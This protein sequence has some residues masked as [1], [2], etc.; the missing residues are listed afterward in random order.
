LP[1]DGIVRQGTE[2]QKGVTSWGN[3]SAVPS[4]S[5]RL[6]DQVRL[7]CQR[8]HYSPRTAEA[9]VYWVRNYVLFHRKRH[10][11]E[12]G[13][14]DLEAFLNHLAAE[15][16]VSASTQSQA[17]N[18]LVFLYRNVLEL[19]LGWMNKRERAKRSRPLPVVLTVD[20]VRQVLVHL[21]GTPRL[22]A[23]LIYGTGLRVMEC[24]SLQVQD[25]DFGSGRDGSGRIVVRSG[26]AS[27][28]WVTLLPKN[29]FES[30]RKYLLDCAIHHQNA[31]RRG[32]GSAPLPHA[33]ARKYP[34]AACAW[35]WQYVFP[36]SVEQRDPVTGRLVR[37]HM[38]PETL[39]RA[40]R[41]TVNASRIHK[42]ATVHT[43]RHCFATHLLQRGHDIRTIQTL[44]G[45]SSLEA[46]MIYTH[47]L[48]NQDQVRSP[49]DAL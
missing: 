7:A 34:N 30:L 16:R 29:L 32:G 11:R 35:K 15:R 36:S 10:P 39:Q 26:K 22:M 13:A 44:M 46:T 33:L 5:P 43:L 45:H 37:W 38:S 24:A 28:D 17:L 19:D 31:C 40:F 20:E 9:Y 41:T 21:H 48:P 27:K 25:I 18:A 8:R 14:K 2:F 49:L 3:S 6:L 23:S 12:L 42:H 1:A 47:V 4:Q